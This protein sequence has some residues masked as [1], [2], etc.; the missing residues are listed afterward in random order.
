M[1]EYKVAISTIANLGYTILGVIIGAQVV[2]TTAYQIITSVASE[3]YQPLMTT[4]IFGIALYAIWVFLTRRHNLYDV[5]DFT[6][7]RV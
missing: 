7:K 6:S 3:I 5:V 2:D 4:T 1:N